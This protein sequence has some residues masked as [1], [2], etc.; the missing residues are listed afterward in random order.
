MEDKIFKAD[1]NQPLI[2]NILDLLVILFIFLSLFLICKFFEPKIEYIKDSKM[3]ICHYNKKN[4]R[5]WFIIY[6]E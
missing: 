1:T 5:G 2:M 3:W 4:S 6:K